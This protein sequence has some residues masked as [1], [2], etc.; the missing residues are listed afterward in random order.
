MTVKP[1]TSATAVAHEEEAHAKK[2]RGFPSAF[3]CQLCKR[4]KPPAA[5]RAEYRVQFGWGA[6]A[7]F[8]CEAHLPKLLDRQLKACVIVDGMTCTV[9]RIEPEYR[10]VATIRR[11]CPRHVEEKART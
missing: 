8:V 1:P 9:D 6:G 10:R 2:L 11:R 4:Q 7:Y 3:G 5:T